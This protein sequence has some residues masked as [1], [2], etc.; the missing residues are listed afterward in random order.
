MF[1]GLMVAVSLGQLIRISIP[2]WVGGPLVAALL[3]STTEMS[4]TEFPDREVAALGTL[5]F[6]VLLAVLMM[7]L[8]IN[9]F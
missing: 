8:F 3:R 7:E 2:G 6:G 5:S 1:S 4:N 9:S